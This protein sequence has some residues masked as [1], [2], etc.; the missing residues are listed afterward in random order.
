MGKP[1]PPRNPVLAGSTAS[2]FSIAG[3]DIYLTTK[4]PIIIINAIK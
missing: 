1:S 2:I 3:P 4:N